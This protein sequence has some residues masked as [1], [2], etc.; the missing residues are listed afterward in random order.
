MAPAPLS[1]M[2]AKPL[3]SLLAPFSPSMNLPLSKVASPEKE[4]EGGEKE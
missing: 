3:T 1:T 4:R 2:V